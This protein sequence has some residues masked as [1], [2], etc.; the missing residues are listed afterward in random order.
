MSVDP[1][2]QQIAAAYKATRERTLAT[3][4]KSP[5]AGA[6]APPPYHLTN[7]AYAIG[8]LFTPTAALEPLISR[9]F[10]AEGISVVP[11][12]SLHYT[13]L[14]LTPHQWD[15]DDQMPDPS[16]LAAVTR[17][18]L[19]N[20][21]FEISDLR[22]LPLP[23]ALLL[24]GLPSVE[25]LDARDRLIGDLMKFTTTATWLKERYG[26]AFPPLFWHTTLARSRTTL[27]PPTLRSLCRE[28]AAENFGY[29]SMPFPRLHAVNF[30]WTLRR[31]I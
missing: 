3:W 17:S 25:M 23:N 9:V 20:L 31:E 22:L 21:R 10:D 18:H 26:P 16:F 4:E 6:E 11:R 29:L 14:A 2:L 7:R 28:F 15:D 19:L 24:A 27:L 12:D 1:R 30:D 13:F 8:S 5:D